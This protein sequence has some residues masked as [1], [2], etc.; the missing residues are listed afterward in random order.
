MAALCGSE[1]PIW[2]K[3]YATSP[4]QSKP[5]GDAPRGALGDDLGLLAPRLLELGALLLHLAAEL[6]HL[7]DDPGVLVGDALDG[8][9]PVEQVAHARGA[10][11]HLHR[12][13]VPGRVER[14]E[15]V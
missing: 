14:H 3:T 7:A 13:L 11:Q 4:E 6:A 15:P 10:E 5:D 8:V 1:T 12:A 9:E 2:P